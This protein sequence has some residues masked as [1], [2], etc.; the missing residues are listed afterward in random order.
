M[1]K[2]KA[3]PLHVALNPR[4][5]EANSWYCP[6]TGVNLFLDSPESKDLSGFDASKLDAVKRGIRAGLLIVSQGELPEGVD[7]NEI[8]LFAS[9]RSRW[10]EEF[11]D[12]QKQAQANWEA[13]TASKS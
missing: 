5:P 12:V 6:T 4:N 11:D 10:S 3:S 7:V 13:L 1:P 2:E 9:P 8:N